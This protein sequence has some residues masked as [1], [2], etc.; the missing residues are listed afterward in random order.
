MPCSPRKLRLGNPHGCVLLQVTGEPIPA[1]SQMEDRPAGGTRECFH[2]LPAV[3][4]VAELV[5]RIPTPRANDMRNQQAAFRAI[6]WKYNLVIALH[7][8]LLWPPLFGLIL[9]YGMRY[10]SGY[11]R[12]KAP[13]RIPAKDCSNRRQNT[14]PSKHTG[15]NGYETQCNSTEDALSCYSR[16]GIP[17]EKTKDYDSPGDTSPSPSLG[18]TKQDCQRNSTKDVFPHAFP[19][20]LCHRQDV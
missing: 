18:T 17:P 15:A 14:P 10:G 5:V 7:S 6:G 3:R 11:V 1:R 8:V 9:E 16:N 2:T 13:H 4:A 20:S 12:G 19:L